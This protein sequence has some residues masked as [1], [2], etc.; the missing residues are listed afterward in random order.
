[1]DRLTGWDNGN[2]YCLKCFEDG[3]CPDMN[4]DKCA[5][6]EHEIAIFDR[7]ARYED[8]GLTPEE[9]T[10][11][12]DFVNSQ[13]AKLLAENCELRASIRQ[14]TTWL[15]PNPGD[16]SRA[17]ERARQYLIAELGD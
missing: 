16:G 6:C 7:L 13:C 3:G 10:K 1:M 12:N 8:T 4:S 2:P 5:L 14:A 15:T 9:I 17:V 11:M